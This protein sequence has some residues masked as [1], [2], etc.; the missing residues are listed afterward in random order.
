M[1]ELSIT[2]QKAVGSDYYWK[3]N[4]LAEYIDNKMTTVTV[5]LAVRM[6]GGGGKGTRDP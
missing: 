1:A 6:H 3:L 4:K 5:P 2:I